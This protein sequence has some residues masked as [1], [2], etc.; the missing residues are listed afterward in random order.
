MSLLQRRLSAAVAKWLGEDDS[1]VA[2]SRCTGNFSGMRLPQSVLPTLDLLD[3]APA[4]TAGFD[5]LRGLVTS[6]QQLRTRGFRAAEIVNKVRMTSDRTAAMW[7]PS[8]LDLASQI[9][10]ISL[11]ALRTHPAVLD[12]LNQWWRLLRRLADEMEALNPALR[13]RPEALDMARCTEQG[14][15]VGD[16]VD[17]A[18]YVYFQALLAAALYPTMEEADVIDSAADDF[19]GDTEAARARG[20]LVSEQLIPLQAWLDSILELATVW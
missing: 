7:Q 9:E 1:E 12:E 4:E 14:L 5:T 16:V 17:R 18:T 13:L 19:L 3:S 2:K 20:F 6:S 15:V 8:V 11:R 10:K